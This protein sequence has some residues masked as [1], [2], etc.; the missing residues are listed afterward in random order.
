DKALSGDETENFEFPLYTKGGNRVQVL[1]N[2]TTRRDSLGNVVGMV[3]V[4]QDI[5]QRMQTDQELQELNE[6]L[7]QRVAQRTAQ[8]EETN[9]QLR[10]ANQAKSDFL[11][12]M[13]HELRTPLNS[14]I[15]MSDIML[16]KFFGELTSKQEEY[17]RD[18]NNSGQHLLELINDILDLSKVEA[19]Y[20]PLELSDVNIQNLLETSLIFVRERATR[21][22]IELSLDISDDIPVIL[23]DELKVKQTLV[24][25]LSNAVKFTPDGGL[26]EIKAHTEPD[27]IQVC[28]SDNGIGIALDDQ[29]RI[30]EQFQRTESALTRKFE[31]A[32][33]GLALAK[34]FVEQHGG[35]IWLESEVGVGSRFYLNLPFTPPKEEELEMN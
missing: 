13:S 20:S 33:L 14:V 17:T 31:G 6:E 8:L 25:L 10:Q 5:T 3:G 4:G 21:H 29:E 19:G 7:E 30:F 26:V 9:L 35:R 1:L 12:N 11:A 16:E 32:G 34:R 28:I 15:A 2:A 18:I 27:G 23:A 24:N 22:G